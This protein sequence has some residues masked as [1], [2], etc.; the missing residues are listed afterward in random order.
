MTAPAVGHA[1]WWS[2]PDLGLAVGVAVLVLIG[3][4]VSVADDVPILLVDHDGRP[5]LPT[6]RAVLEAAVEALPLTFRRVAPVLVFVV[7]ATVSLIDEAVNHRPEPLPLAVLVALYTLAVLRRPLVAA[8]A[9]VCYLAGLAVDEATAWTDL[10]DDQLYIDLLVIAGTV[11]LG[12]AIRRNRA[13]TSRAVRQSVEAS[14][15]AEEQAREAAR[16]ERAR[17][18]REMHD[19]LGHQLSVIVAQAAATR[20]VSP[21]R[22]QATTAALDSIETVGRD[23][24]SGLRRLTGLLRVDRDPPQGGRAWLAELDAGLEQVRRA[25]LPVELTVEGA[26]RDLPADVALNALRV[27]QEALTNVLRHAGPTRATVVLSFRDADLGIEVHDTGGAG[28]R[29]PDGG[30]GGHGL[31][32]M[33][34]RV[35]L[36]GGELT[37]GP[38]GGRGFRVRARLPV[39]TG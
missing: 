23:A 9:A 10:S 34:Q 7:V 31:A 3:F 2:L 37:A 25:G 28:Y 33:A 27:V 1:R 13:R 4:G 21:D 14:L 18:A 29:A 6:S 11:V 16:E 26:P 5:H 17:I 20:R 35:Q 22:P 39:V 19:L 12:V 30:S 24:I 38:D 36:L 8:T 15:A 32:G